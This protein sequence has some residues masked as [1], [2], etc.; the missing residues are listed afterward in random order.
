VLTQRPNRNF[1]CSLATAEGFIY[2]TPVKDEPEQTDAARL[3][4]QAIHNLLGKG[5]DAEIEGEFQKGWE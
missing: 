5:R 2:T 1:D 4:H 3:G